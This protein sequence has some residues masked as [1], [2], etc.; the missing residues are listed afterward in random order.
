MAPASPSGVPFHRQTGFSTHHARNWGKGAGINFSP[1]SPN[2]CWTCSTTPGLRSQVPQ[3]RTGGSW[4]DAAILLRIQGQ[5]ACHAPLTGHHSF[6]GTLFPSNRKLNVLGAR[7]TCPPRLG[8]LPCIKL[9]DPYI[10]ERGRVINMHLSCRH[11]KTTS[12]KR[13]DFFQRETEEERFHSTSRSR[14]K[15]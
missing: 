14:S 11:R 9:R 7:V 12:C 6:Y 2:E 5:L 10:I 15:T 4:I 3:S 13:N 8:V 1:S